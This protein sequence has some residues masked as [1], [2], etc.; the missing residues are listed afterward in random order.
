MYIISSHIINLLIVKKIYIDSC[1]KFI[2]NQLILKKILHY[3]FT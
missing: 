1:K 3:F 2:H